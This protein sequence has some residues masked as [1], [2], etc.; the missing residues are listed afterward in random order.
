MSL[1]ALALGAT[2]YL[3]ATRSDLATT[4]FGN[5]ISGLRSAVICLEDAVSDADLPAALHNVAALLRTLPARRDQSP[6]LFVRPRDP[7]MLARILLMP[8]AERLTGFVLPKINADNFPTWLALPLLPEH[9]L[10][11]TLETREMFDPAEV[12]RLREQLLA[13]QERIL[14]LRI[15]GNDLLQALGCR[16]SSTRTAYEGPLGSLIAALVGAFAPWGFAL[17]APVLERFDDPALLRAEVARDIEHGLF[18]KTVIHP[19]QVA[20]VHAALAV[21]SAEFAQARAILAAD[22]PAV[23]AR[24][25]AMCEPATHHRWAQALIRRAALFGVADS[26]PLARQA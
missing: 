3:P 10:M 14:V 18:T 17:S 16:R 6:L 5:R 1:D 22:A 11:P 20:I 13:V 21:A 4:L 2:L 24:G 26:L 12:R 23:F 15:G 9:R 8:G 25:G 7:A 19:A